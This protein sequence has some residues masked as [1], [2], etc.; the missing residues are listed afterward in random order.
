MDYEIWLKPV[1]EDAQ[2][3]FREEAY[4]KALKEA[5][6]RFNQAG[7][8]ARNRREIYAW[9][10]EGNLIKLWFSSSQPLEKPTKSFRYFSKGLIDCSPAFAV[11]A[12]SGRLLKGVY[13]GAAPKAPEKA[14]QGGAAGMSD[15]EMLATLLHWCMGKELQSAWEKKARRAAIGEIKGI[16]AVRRAER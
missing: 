13:V 12:S 11:L 5:V 6:D 14:G 16:L 7:K 10:A 2:V 8:S 15:E 3:D 9:S 4:Q 1:S